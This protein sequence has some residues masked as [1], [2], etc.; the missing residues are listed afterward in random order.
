MNLLDVDILS[1]T[2]HVCYIWLIIMVNVGRI[3]HKWMVLVYIDVFKPSSTG[4]IFLSW[5]DQ[6]KS[7]NATNYQRFETWE[8][9]HQKPL[10]FVNRFR[11]CFVSFFPV[12]VI[13]RSWGKL[14]NP[15]DSVAK[16]LQFLATIA[17]TNAQLRCTEAEKR[18]YVLKKN[19]VLSKCV[20]AY[21][22]SPIAQH[23][24]THSSMCFCMF[25]VHCWLWIYRYLHILTH[26]NSNKNKIKVGQYK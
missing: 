15:C 19:W 13:K 21:I 2:V 24:C 25:C 20:G 12:S 3:Y 7:Q 18:T 17:W 22:C 1:H 10:R 9:Q 14:G 8:I 6:G 5:S 4:H 26:K 11:C 16:F 23:M